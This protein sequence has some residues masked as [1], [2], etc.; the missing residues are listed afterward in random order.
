MGSLRRE[1]NTL[2]PQCFHTGH[3]SKINYLFDYTYISIK[4]RDGKGKFITGM[5]GTNL[6]YYIFNLSILYK[7]AF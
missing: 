7:K 6:S 2:L 1:C 4:G 5:M 3:S